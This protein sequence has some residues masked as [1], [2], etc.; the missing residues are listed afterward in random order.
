MLAAHV[1]LCE[2]RNMESN[3]MLEEVWR[4]KN[5]WARAADDDIH[6]L[7]QNT[8]Q[9]AADHPHPDSAVHGGK[10]NCGTWQPNW[11]G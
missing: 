1:V 8:R 7:C 3:P 9:W 5:A 11:P 6:R 10:K 4:V 2:T